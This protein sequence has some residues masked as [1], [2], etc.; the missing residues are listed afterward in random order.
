MKG[1]IGKAHIPE[2]F[3]NILETWQ[4]QMLVSEIK[5]LVDLDDFIFD[6]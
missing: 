3:P 5:V 1:E 4:L 2:I 6:F